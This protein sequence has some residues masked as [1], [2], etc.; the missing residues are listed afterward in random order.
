MFSASGD[1]SEA[2]LVI[3]EG[4]GL[5]DCSGRCVPPHAQLVAA[6][7]FC[8][9]GTSAARCDANAVSPTV[10]WHTAEM[11]FKLLVVEREDGG[12]AGWCSTTCINC[13][14][15]DLASSH[16]PQ[17]APASQEAFR[18]CWV[19][20][21]STAHSL[22]VESGPLGKV[23]KPE[24]A[25]QAWPRVTFPAYGLGHGCFRPGL[26]L[27]WIEN[28]STPQPDAGACLWPPAR[29]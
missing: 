24:P 16:Q 29:A 23:E 28:R 6:D 13:N 21:G 5:P 4:Q 8:C 15:G 20:A 18:P 27:Q 22:P 2:L 17:G 1:S 9:V 25:W 11:A 26:L 19:L 14:T 7:G 3:A 10:Q 12:G